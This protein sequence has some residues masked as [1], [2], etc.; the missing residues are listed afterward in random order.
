VHLKLGLLK[1]FLLEYNNCKHHSI[2]I[3]FYGRNLYFRLR[4][5]REL[6]KIYSIIYDAINYLAKHSFNIG[7]QK[8]R[9][10]IYAYSELEKNPKFEGIDFNTET[11]IYGD[12]GFHLTCWDKTKK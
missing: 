10:A 8:L 11:V 3:L 12:G 7:L 9:S 5:K 4:K 1:I 6:L 2:A